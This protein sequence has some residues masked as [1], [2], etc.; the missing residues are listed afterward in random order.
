MVAV[1]QEIEAYAAAKEEPI[2]RSI[3]RH[4][5]VDSDF[6]TGDDVGD[7]CSREVVSLTTTQQSLIQD[8]HIMF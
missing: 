4:N 3:D 7:A 6:L 5:S 1:A 8:L 2:H